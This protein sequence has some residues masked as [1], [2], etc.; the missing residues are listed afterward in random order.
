MLGS[1]E[2]NELFTGVHVFSLLATFLG[3]SASR[4]PFDDACVLPRSGRCGV[5]IVEE[6]LRW[7][8]HYSKV[9]ALKLA[10][11]LGIRCA[12]IYCRCLLPPSPPIAAVSLATADHSGE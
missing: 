6:C 8:R 1:S 7:K 3:H 9:T 4:A 12:A 11:A 10:W 5:I 2:V